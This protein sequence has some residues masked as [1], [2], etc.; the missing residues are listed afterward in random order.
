MTP[1]VSSLSSLHHT[2]RYD[3]DVFFVTG[4]LLKGEPMP[5]SRLL[6]QG[7]RG[8]VCSPH[9]HPNFFTCSYSRMK[10][11]WHIT[12]RWWWWGLG[13]GRYGFRVFCLGNIKGRNDVEEAGSSVSIILHVRFEF[14]TKICL[15][16][17]AP[18]CPLKRNWCF[19]GNMISWQFHL[20]LYFKPENGDE[21]CI[22]NVGWFPTDHKVL[23]PRK[24][25]SS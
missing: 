4:P 8:A 2:N 14:V 25:N 23:C 24:R 13:G 10:S 21:C 15:W 1:A 12:W 22:W 9:V 18:Y 7:M 11:T 17:I 19:G 3:I 16:D 6:D 5:R 20:W